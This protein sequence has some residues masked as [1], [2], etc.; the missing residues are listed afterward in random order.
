MILRIEVMIMDTIEN[1]TSQSSVIVGV[2]GTLI[3]LG[4]AGMFAWMFYQI[5]ISKTS[6]VGFVD[7]RYRF[8]IKD[9]GT[10][11]SKEIKDGTYNI[12]FTY[13]DRHGSYQGVK[14]VSRSEYEESQTGDKFSIYYNPTDPGK[15]L[16][17]NRGRLGW[18]A[19]A[20]LVPFSITF[21][22]GTWVMIQ[23]LRAFFA[24]R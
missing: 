22:L 20:L 23:T 19:V 12:T 10:V 13:P 11:V 15:W 17:P 14:Q 18:G 6:K 4:L 16:L 2:L 24:S 21:L 3:L 8:Y 9:I 1:T 7:E 5:Y